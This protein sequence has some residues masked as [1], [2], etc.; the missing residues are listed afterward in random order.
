VTVGGKKEDLL[1]KKSRALRGSGA[2]GNYHLANFVNSKKGKN[3]KVG[4]HEQGGGV[5]SR[6]VVQDCPYDHRKTS[7]GIR[8]ELKQKKKRIESQRLS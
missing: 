2:G 5:G 7:G 6:K 3:R 4:S 1:L 8:K